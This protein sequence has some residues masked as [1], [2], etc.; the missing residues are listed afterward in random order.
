MRIL[1]VSQ[2]YPGP[3]APDLGDVR[4]RARARARGARPRDRAGRR[5][6]ARGGRGRHLELARDV[7]RGRAPVP[8]GRRLRA[9]PRA[10][11]PPRS[12]RGS[13]AARRHGARAGR[14]ERGRCPASRRATR[15]RRRR[16]AAVVAVSEWLRDRLVSAGARRREAKSAVID[17]GVDLERFASATPRPLAPRSA[18]RRRAGVPLRRLADGAQERAPARATRSSAAATGSSSSS[19]T[20]RCAARSRDATACASRAPSRTSA[21][22]D[23]IAAADVVCQPSLVEP[24]GLATL[25]AMA[26]GRSVVATRSAGRPSSCPPDAGVLVDPED[27]DAVA[28]GLADAAALPRPNA[29]ARAAAERHDVRRQAERVE[30]LLLRSARDRRA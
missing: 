20:G 5:R 27:D 2:M 13:G 29:A 1:L 17:C 10:G 12:A 7:L 8:A 23:W 9:L 14:R 15:L 4:R 19:A 26:S 3:A 21:C 18:G 22:R 16:A 11:R 25:E 28:R 30:E 24:F 6:P